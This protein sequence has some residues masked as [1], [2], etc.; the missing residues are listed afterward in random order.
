MTF[1]EKQLLGLPLV[2]DVDTDAKR[3]ATLMTLRV[4]RRIS[5][6]S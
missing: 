4:S 2:P 6:H 1:F 5:M 3:F